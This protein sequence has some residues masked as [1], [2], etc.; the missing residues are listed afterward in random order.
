[1]QIECFTLKDKTN[2]DPACKNE[3]LVVKLSSANREVHNSQTAYCLPTRFIIEEENTASAQP[4]KSLMP[5]Y[6]NK[7]LSPVSA[8]YWDLFVLEK[9]LKSLH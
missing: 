5:T 9:Q 6:R 7:M 4:R 1:M 3:Q 2:L 8:K